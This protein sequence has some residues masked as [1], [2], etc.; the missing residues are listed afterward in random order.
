VEKTFGNCVKI[1]CL[2]TSPVGFVQY[3][4]SKYFPR[5]VDYAS[6]PPSEDAV[7]IACLYIISKEHRRKG[8]GTIMLRNL[9]E[10][11]RARGFKTAETF[12][13]ADSE[14]NPSGPLT[15]YLKHGFKVVCR[16]D[17]FPLV[18]LEI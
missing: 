11:L 6:G 18:R 2:G 5:V 14:N 8:Y 1:A 13:R 3:A 9:L 17:D 12:A 16:R 7:F 15:F 4:P 10:E